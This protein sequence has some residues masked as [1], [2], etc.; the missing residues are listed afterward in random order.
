VQPAA[1]PAERAVLL[2]SLAGRVVRGGADD[3][4]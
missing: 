1:A 4:L 3:I 2:V